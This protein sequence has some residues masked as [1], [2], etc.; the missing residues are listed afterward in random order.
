MTYSDAIAL[1][2]MIDAVARLRAWARVAPDRLLLRTDGRSYSY[3][4]FLARAEAVRAALHAAG[5]VS[6]GRVVSL[7]DEYDDFFAG[8]MGTWLAGAVFVPL[9]TTLPEAALHTLIA[10]TSPGAVLVSPPD[11][12]PWVDRLRLP[13][14]PPEKGAGAPAPAVDS[15]RPLAPEEMAMILFTSGSTG[16]PKGAC[17]RLAAVSANA[18]YTAQ[19][20]GLTPDDSIFINTPPYFASAICHFLTVLAAGGGLAAKRGF[21]FGGALLDEL[22]RLECTGFGGAPAHLVRVVQGLAEPR[23]TRVRLW[24]SSGDHL[25]PSVLELSR[26]MLPDVRVFNV[27]GLTEVAGRLCI[28]TPDEHGAGAGSVGLPIGAMRV[29]AR[30][31]T[32]ARL[33]P[34]EIGELYVSG[35]L[36][37]QGYLDAPELTARALTPYGFRSGDFGAVDERGHVYVAGRRDDIVKCGAEKVST[38]QVQ[39]ALLAMGWFADA[40]VAAL[41]DTVMGH[42]LVA[43]VV[44]VPG[45]AF[46]ARDVL[47]RLHGVLPRASVPTRIVTVDQ[48]PR[49]DSGKIAREELTRL[50]G[51]ACE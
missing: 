6:G 7:V 36:L 10:K 11:R 40:A 39:E 13:V 34:G 2:V 16:I 19:R 17:H 43:L 20:L 3:A 48:I 50:A 23:R 51:V 27:Y 29:V 46:I 24:V 42:T 45:G 30:D 32:G 41:P 33:P 8:L 44:P 4:Q 15:G 35:P 5:H 26:L 9:N 22:E 47:A 18:G 1:D 31:E 37:M 25:A 14:P 21:L 12:F 38:L 49:L 28:L